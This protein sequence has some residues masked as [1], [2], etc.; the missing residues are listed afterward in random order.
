[1]ATIGHIEEFHEDKEE[2]VSMQ[3]DLN[4]SLPPKESQTMTIYIR[5]V[6][7]TVIGTKAYKQLRSLIAPVE[8]GDSDYATLL[9][10]M[11]NHYIPVLSEIVQQFCF[12]SRFLQ[13]SASVS[14]DIAELRALAKFCDFGDTLSLMIRDRLVCRINDENTQ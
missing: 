4:I 5:S 7:L 14:T 8:L 9:D 3:N 1:M 6:Y 2:W 10:T 11:K 13:P 12:N